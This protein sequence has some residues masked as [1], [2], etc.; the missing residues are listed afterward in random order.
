MCL[1]LALEG[2]CR[3]CDDR[4]GVCIYEGQPKVKLTVFDHGMSVPMCC[5]CSQ[6]LYVT[7]VAAPWHGAIGDS[8]GGHRR[9]RGLL[10]AA[11]ADASTAA[12]TVNDALLEPVLLPAAHGRSLKVSWSMVYSLVWCVAL[13]LCCALLTLHLSRKARGK[14]VHCLSLDEGQVVVQLL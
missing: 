1:L 9:R 14:A 2:R 5:P 6:Y 11:A 7:Q 10:A 4:H 13:L 3:Q 12:A 8:S